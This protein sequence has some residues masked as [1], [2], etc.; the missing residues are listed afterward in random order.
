LMQLASRMAAASQSSDAFAKVKGLIADMI[1]KLEASAQADATEKAYCDKELSETAEKKEDKGEEI[2]KITTRI[3]QMDAK[4]V[5]L[6]EE[7]AALQTALSKLASSQAAIDKIRQEEKDIFAE[8]K[9]E[10]EKGIEGVKMALQLL[11]E[12]YA[13]DGKAHDAAEGAAGGIISLLEVVEADFSKN[14]AEITADEEAAAAEYER[15]TK[16]NELEQTTKEKDVQYKTK[17]AKYLDK[18]SSE[19][20]AD[21]AGVQA[22]LDAVNEYLSKIQKRCIAK[23]EAYEAR[24]ARYAAEIAGL[25]EGLN[26]LESET[27]LVQRRSIRSHL[28]LRGARRA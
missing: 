16:D 3:D 5:E 14:L 19:L 18:S 17:E 28:Q 21:R 12:Y 1:E 7:I 20:S 8:S 24:Q 11:T 27:A 15:T 6:K 26:I 2:E 4:S 23:A 10:L 13:S 25:K 9:A 22:E